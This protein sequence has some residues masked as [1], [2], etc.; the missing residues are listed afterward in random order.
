MPVVDWLIEELAIPCASS[1]PS[2]LLA[3]LGM[4]LVAVV[5]WGQGMIGK[6]V[7]HRII[8]QLLCGM[9]EVCAEDL[10]L[11]RKGGTEVLPPHYENDPEALKR[12][13]R[14]QSRRRPRSFNIVTICEIDEHGQAVHRH[15]AR[16][17]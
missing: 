1:S 12:F 17:G 3:A 16:G 2:T 14:S 6:I 10:T 9:S 7:S 15:V 5:T 4:A 8:Q 13:R 11:D